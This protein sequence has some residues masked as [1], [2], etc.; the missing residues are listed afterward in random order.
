MIKHI[1]LFVILTFWI[2]SAMAQVPDRRKDPFPTEEAW[3]IFPAPFSAPGLGSGVFLAGLWS[4]IAESHSD[5]F[6]G[7]LKGDFDASFAGLLDNHLIDETLIL[8]F[9]GGVI[10]KA[11]VTSYQ[12]RG[13]DTDPNNY[14]TFKVGDGD[15]TGGRI[16]LTFWERRL[17]AFVTQFTQ[18]SRLK[19]VYEADGTLI[20]EP[21]SAPKAKIGML[22]QGLLFDFTDDWGDPREGLKIS[23]NQ[24]RFIGLNSDGSSPE[25]FTIDQNVTAYLPMGKQSTWVFNVF[26]SKAVVTKQGMTDKEK[27]RALLYGKIDC[28]LTADPT[29]CESTIDQ[30]LD[31]TIAANR[32]GTASGLGG[33]SRL[34]AFPQGRF[35]GARTRFIGTEF[36][37]NLTDESVPFNFY[38]I[39]DVRTSMQIAFFKEKASIAETAQNLG[40]DW[41]NSTG[42]GFRLVTASGMVFRLDAATGEEGLNVNVIFDYPWSDTAF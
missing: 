37:W 34:R 1:F 28:S 5:M 4:N 41:R 32:Y 30:Q 40:K 8:D 7:I 24:N 22:S 26:Q 25:Q 14:K 36:R 10:N 42:M 16:M 38:L 29:K 31:D 2:I 39:K 20:Y 17:N 3:Y 6:V 33:V 9:T 18:S 35:K 23:H 11:I 12:G 13:F 21:E 27:L 19:G 15:G